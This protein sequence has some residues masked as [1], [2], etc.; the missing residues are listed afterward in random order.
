M[1]I[2]S[3]KFFLPEFS[4][5]NVYFGTKQLDICNLCFQAKQ[6]KTFEF[7]KGKTED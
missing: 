3:K 5:E 6:Q 1:V 4:F 2:N 7:Q